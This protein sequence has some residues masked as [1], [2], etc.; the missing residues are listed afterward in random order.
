[1]VCGNE[2]NDIIYLDFI[3]SSG[4]IYSDF[5]GVKWFYGCVMAIIDQCFIGTFLG[6]CSP[7]TDFE[8]ASV[9]VK[10]LKQQNSLGRACLKKYLSIRLGMS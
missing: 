7:C 10:A 9:S 6:K 8:K 4:W 5:F 1:M 2:F 3:F